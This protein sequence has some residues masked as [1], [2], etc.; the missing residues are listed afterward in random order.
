MISSHPSVESVAPRR[1][2]RPAL[3]ALSDGTVF[4]GRSFGAVGETA[5]EVVFN[6]SMAGYQEI[7]TDPS[8]RAQIVVMTYP[9]IGSYGVNDEDVESAR[10]QAAGFVVREYQAKPSNWRATRSLHAALESAGIVGIEGIDTRALTRHLRSR[11][12]MEGVVSST[13]VDPAALVERARAVPGMVGRDLVR[14]VTCDAPYEWTGGGTIDGWAASGSTRAPRAPRSFHVVAY[15]YG[16]KWNLL[17]ML[18]DVGA[19]VTV[20]P[21]R[22]SARDALALS[23][24]GIFLSNGPGDPAALPEIVSV[25]RDLLG[26]KPVFGVCLG[27]QLMGLAL[28]GRTFKLKFGHRGA[29]QPVIDLDTRRIAVTSQ[30]HGFAVDGAT[31]GAGARV[32]HLNLNDDTVEGLAHDALRAFSV[33]HHPEASP[34]PHD[35][36]PLFER[37]AQVIEESRGAAVQV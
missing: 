11:G 4:E 17:R 3:L 28:G 33:Q 19:R 36:A 2:A 8:Y 26:K 30:N 18:V 15:D 5:G 35:A 32:T 22:T 23:P 31:L 29:N 21:A 1:D 25:V 20:V 27:H 24:D 12:V 9:L 7:L 10:P 34:G 6:T 13:L 14:E 37:F 16:I